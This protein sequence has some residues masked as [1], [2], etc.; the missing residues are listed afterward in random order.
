MNG[1]N[2][3]D[4]DGS[5]FNENNKIHCNNIDELGNELDNIIVNVASTIGKVRN[6]IYNIEFRQIKDFV[7]TLNNMILKEEEFKIETI[8]HN[9]KDIVKIEFLINSENKNNFIVVEEIEDYKFLVKYELFGLSSFKHFTKSDELNNYIQTLYE[10]IKH[11][12]KSLG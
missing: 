2:D 8:Y 3:I 12:I 10:K 7:W 1:L 11:V 4:I 5:F 6:N 9:Y